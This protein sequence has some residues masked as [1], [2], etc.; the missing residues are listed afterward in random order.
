MKQ[1]IRQ[2]MEKAREKAKEKKQYTKGC[3]CGDFV[4]CKACRHRRWAFIER[5]RALGLFTTPL[6]PAPNR[7]T[8]KCGQ[9]K[10]CLHRAYMKLWRRGN[11]DAIRKL[12]ASN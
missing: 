9:C 11:M 1:K 3:R 6:P 5:R 12:P 7:E 2:L 8:C 10:K 4:N